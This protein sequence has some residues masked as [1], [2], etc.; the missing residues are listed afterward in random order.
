M[1]LLCLQKRTDETEDKGKVTNALGAM[2]AEVPGERAAAWVTLQDPNKTYSEAHQMNGV[3]DKISGPTR[4]A[5]GNKYKGKATDALGAMVVVVP[6]VRATD[7]G[8]LQDPK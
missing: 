4:M 3:Y 7:M 2:V 1:L 6:I 8:T 5:G